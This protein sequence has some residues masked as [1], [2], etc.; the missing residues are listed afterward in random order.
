MRKIPSNARPAS[1]RESLEMGPW[2]ALCEEVRQE[3]GEPPWG[4]VSRTPVPLD[5]MKPRSAPLLADAILAIDVRGAARWLRAL[6]G[7]AGAIGSPAA[8]LHGERLT[9]EHVVPLL[10][11]VVNEDRARIAALAQDLDTEGSALGAVAALGVMPLLHAARRSLD[12]AVPNAWTHSYCPVC[13]AWPTLAEARGVERSRHYRCARCGEAWFAGWHCCPYCRNGDPLRAGALVLDETGAR[14][15]VETCEVCQ[16]YVKTL[17]VLLPFE[18]GDVAL[19]DLDSVG[20]DLAAVARGYHRP[21]SPPRLASARIVRSW[22]R[23]PS[24]TD[25]SGSRV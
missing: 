25:S 3:L 14:H 2:V 15:R 23:P 21:P 12:A 11:A 9:E 7:R 24:A 13:G 17:S 16:G 1:V 20:L 6:F 19:A 18:P 5:S 10:S 22:A 4:S 8:T